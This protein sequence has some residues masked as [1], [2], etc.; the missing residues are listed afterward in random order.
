MAPEI[1]NLKDKQLRYDPICDMFSV[2]VI[3]H[4]I[5]LGTSP[6]PGKE[7]DEV[8]KQNR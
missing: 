2:G 6:F 4:L 7:C 1:S 5:V 3:F 8:L